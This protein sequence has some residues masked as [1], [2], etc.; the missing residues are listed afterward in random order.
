MS[1]YFSRV[2]IRITRKILTTVSLLVLLSA[3]CVIF[4]CEAN[5]D[6]LSKW[7]D[8]SETKKAIISYVSEVTD[9]NNENYIPVE[10]RVAVFDSDGTCCCERGD[11]MPNYFAKYVADYRLKNDQSF[12][13]SEDLL[14]AINNGFITQE[15]QIQILSDLETAEFDLLVD[16]FK[17]ESYPCFNNMKFSEAFYTPMLQLI[18]YLKDNDFSVY[19]VSGTDQEFLRDMEQSVLGLEASHIIGSFVEIKASNEGNE[20]GRYY[21]LKSDDKIIRTGT[22]II[23][24]NF[25][26]VSLISDHIGKI[27]VFC[28]GNSTGDFSMMQY[29]NAN[30]KYKTFGMLISHDDNSR[31]FVY[32]LGEKLNL[33]KETAKDKGYCYVSMQNEFKEIFKSGVTKKE[34]SEFI[35]YQQ[36]TQV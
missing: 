17:E 25:E 36:D 4:L 16:K 28:A 27:P 19:I 3:F 34:P 31:E 32:P 13:P 20:V 9:E 10:D 18:E 7:E 35:M 33:L 14:A 2:K 23:N 26:K 12:V 1:G 24:D 21:N 15:Q 22:S 5:I 30:S 11:F 8:T 6:K 29:S